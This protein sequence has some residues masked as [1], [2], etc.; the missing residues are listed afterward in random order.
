MLIIIRG[1]LMAVIED[2]DEVCSVCDGS[3]IT[4]PE[5]HD[6]NEAEK[7]GGLEPQPIECQHCGGSGKEPE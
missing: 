2:K 5:F 7:N 3:R 4:K 6:M 1:E